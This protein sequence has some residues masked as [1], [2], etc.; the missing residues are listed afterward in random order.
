M[1][2]IILTS[3]FLSMSASTVVYADNVKNNTCPSNLKYKNINME[4]MDF[5][6][7]KYDDHI[8]AILKI[9]LDKNKSWKEQGSGWFAAGFGAQTM[10]G[11][12]MF[13][14]VPQKSDNEKV[15]YDV[16]ANIGG[17]Y[18][19][20]KPLNTKPKK[21]EIKILSSALGNIEFAL[22]PKKVSNLADSGTINM[23]FSHS[24]AGVYKFVPPHVS[25]Y[26]DKKMVIK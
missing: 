1:K 2:K 4:D 3:L 23:I 24:K 26:D 20:T 10:K 19:P 8:C 13:I 16:F 17:A 22:Y 21:G 14:F 5:K 25:A 9:N 6:Y 18:G 15:K 12:N 11:S 7:A